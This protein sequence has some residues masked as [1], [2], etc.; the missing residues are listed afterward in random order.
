MTRNLS[1][2]ATGFHDQE[3]ELQG[4]MTRNL[5]PL[6]TGFHDQEFEPPWYLCY[7]VP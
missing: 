4:S 2:L 1:P 3:F 6:A 7:R 5:S